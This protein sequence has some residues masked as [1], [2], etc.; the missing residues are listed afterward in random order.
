MPLKLVA[1]VGRF[2]GFLFYFLDVRHR[3]VAVNNLL[4]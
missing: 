3:R 1:L 2:G 4:A